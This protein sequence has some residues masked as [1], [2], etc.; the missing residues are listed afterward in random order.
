MTCRCA[1]G[2][3]G[4]SENSPFKHRA[5][6]FLRVAEMM[7]QDI[8]ELTALDEGE[9]QVAD[10]TEPECYFDR[11]RLTEIED[12]LKTHE[13][14]RAKAKSD[15]I[16]R[17]LKMGRLLI[18]A[19]RLLGNGRYGHFMDWV[20]VTYPFSESSH[21]TAL[22]YA[23]LA[24]AYDANFVK[25]Q[26]ILN[27]GLGEAYKRAREELERDRSRDA[28]CDSG[29]S[30]REGKSSAPKREQ[31]HWPYARPKAGQILHLEWRSDTSRKVAWVW[32]EKDHDTY[33]YLLLHETNG[34]HEATKKHYRAT[35]FW[36]GE[37]DLPANWEALAYGTLRAF[38]NDM[39]KPEQHVYDYHPAIRSL[40]RE[41]TSEAVRNLQRANDHSHHSRA[42]H[43]LKRELEEMRNRL[44]RAELDAQPEQRP[45]SARL[46]RLNVTDSGRDEQEQQTGA[47]RNDTR[48]ERTPGQKLDDED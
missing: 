23:S 19:R 22:N 35:D 36:D 9:M 8:L 17:I 6:R 30:K 14:G 33:G 25:F 43:R 10:S 3:H 4:W 21:Q 31:P 44:A 16:D 39:T 41:W 29:M 47:I 20:K 7:M 1:R 2:D 37:E 13:L 40:L 15:Q 45:P 11:T 34:D 24:E 32:P 12:E 18:E 42:M 48:R 5:Q 38:G 46:A 27:L 26:T 28:G